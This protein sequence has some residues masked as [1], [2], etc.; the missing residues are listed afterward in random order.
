MSQKRI[1]RQQEY[2][3]EEAENRRHYHHDSYAHSS[4]RSEYT[5]YSGRRNNTMAPPEDVLD[6]RKDRRVPL[7]IQH[8]TGQS[9]NV[10]IEN[11]ILLT[12]LVAS[13]YGLYNL[14]IYLL[15]QA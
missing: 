13:I 6:A 10:L 15:N 7:S 11:V 3:L 9:R 1:S 12:I 4:Y 5:Q 14:T 8:A 2:A